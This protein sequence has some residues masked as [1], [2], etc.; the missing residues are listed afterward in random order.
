MN[1]RGEEW[2]TLADRRLLHRRQLLRAS[3]LGPSRRDVKPACWNVVAKRRVRGI[4]SLLRSNSFNSPSMP[5]TLPQSVREHFGEQVAEDF[6][7]WFA[8]N[9]EYELVT[10]SEYR[11]I[12][13]RLDAIDERFAVIDEQFEKVDE[14]FEHV[15][16]RFDQMEDRFNERFEQVDQRFEQVDQRLEQVDQRFESMEE[17]FDKRFE[18]M[19]AKLDRMND[20]ILSMTRWLIGLVALFG[21]LVTALLAVAQ[22]TG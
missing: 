10:K 20:R 22:F 8:E 19:D 12:L 4:L 9:V 18:G 2:K 5:T 14:R 11:K 1:G 16:E 7:R 21:S 3:P 6:S 17:R 15:D 13:S